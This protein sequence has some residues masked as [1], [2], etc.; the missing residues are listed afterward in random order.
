MGVSH[1][2]GPRPLAVVPQ[3][4][5]GPTTNTDATGL[6]R[7]LLPDVRKTL[8]S[9]AKG[10]AGGLSVDKFFDK[11]DTNADG[12]ITQAEAGGRW[13]HGVLGELLKLQEDAGASATTDA[14]GG[15][16]DTPPPPDGGATASGGTTDTSGGT[17]PTAGGAGSDT[18]TA[19]AGATDAGASGGADTTSG[20]DLLTGLTPPPP[21]GDIVPDPS[22][23]L[24]GSAA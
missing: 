3:Q 20:T 22:Q 18:T 9:Q 13:G 4:Q 19:T 8:P 10:A 5:S 11:W 21:T 12:T 15:T 2:G 14:T 17:D 6:D 24:D 23:L 7:N 1:V 16:P